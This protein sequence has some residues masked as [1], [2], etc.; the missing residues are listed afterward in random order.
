MI[1]QFEMALLAG[2]A[3]LASVAAPAHAQGN[4][5]I[6]LNILR[7]CAKIDDTAAR[8]ACYDRNIG[9]DASTGPSTAPA[10]G[11]AVPRSEPRAPSGFASETVQPRNE[12]APQRDERTSAQVAA[13]AERAPGLYVITLDDGAE[14]QFTSSAPFSYQP[15]RPGS[16]V[17]IRRG[18]LGSFLLRYEGQ[19]SV[20]VL[21][22]R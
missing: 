17:D 8:V 14:W 12:P 20:R 13:I 15:P 9:R 2:T 21:R 6:L 4:D 11:D 22:V 3:F 16:T 7:E 10:V 1:R 19:P 5:A 18:A